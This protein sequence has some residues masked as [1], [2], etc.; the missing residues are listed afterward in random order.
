M[1]NFRGERLMVSLAAGFGGMAL[2]LAC[3]GLYGVVTQAVTARTREIGVRIA[4]GATPRLVMASVLRGVFVQIA[5]GFV[6]GGAAALLAGRLLE[7]LL[8]GVS[9][10]DP[11]VLALSACIL[12]LCAA[13]AAA[14]PAARAA[15][16]DPIRALRIE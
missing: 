8:F 3:L 11:R 4:I 13:I 10:R 9:G 15:R 5:A 7:S 14:I 1:G 12:G 16:I 6:I 2:L